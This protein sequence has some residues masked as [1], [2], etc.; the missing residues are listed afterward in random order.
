MARPALCR[1]LPTLIVCGFGVIAVVQS[2]FAGQI[3]QT[4]YKK[5]RQDFEMDLNRVMDDQKRK[6]EE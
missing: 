2:F 5:N 6:R 4:I 1:A 3:L